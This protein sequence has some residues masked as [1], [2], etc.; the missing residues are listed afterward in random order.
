MVYDDM[1]RYNLHIGFTR[2][3]A[4]RAF[5]KGYNPKAITVRWKYL[6]GLLGW[7]YKQNKRNGRK[8]EEHIAYMNFIRQAK[9][10]YRRKEVMPIV[11]LMLEDGLSIRQIS[12]MLGIPK[13]TL[14]RWIK[15][16]ELEL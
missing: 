16:E 7:E 15:Q 9:A 14:S 8:R 11:W 6:C 4:H 1:E 10:K 2:E 5:E 3:E 12:S 13:S